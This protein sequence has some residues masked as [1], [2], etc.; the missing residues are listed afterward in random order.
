MNSQ[1]PILVALD[2]LAILLLCAQLVGVLSQKNLTFKI[3][4]VGGIFVLIC[5]AA[6][7]S[8]AGPE[9][10]R[11]PEPPLPKKEPCIVTLEAF[12]VRASSCH[13]LELQ[14]CLSETAPICANVRGITPQ[15][16][17]ECAM[18][19]LRAPCDDMM[20]DQCIGIA[21][22]RA[23]RRRPVPGARDL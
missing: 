10:G 8:C 9:A 1:P 21:E 13:L 16:A 18:A 3:K 23:V 20:P 12:C 11:P 15:E 6:I 2:F 17:D 19:V 5:L 7:I 14:T 22:P 4:L